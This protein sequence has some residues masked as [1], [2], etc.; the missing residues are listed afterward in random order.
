MVRGISP[1]YHYLNWNPITDLSSG[2]ILPRDALHI[3]YVQPTRSTA[4]QIANIKTRLMVPKPRNRP[5]RRLL[6]PRPDAGHPNSKLHPS[7]RIRATRR[8]K[9]PS[10]MAV[11]VH[12]LRGDHHPRR[13]PG[14]H[15]PPRNARQTEPNCAKQIRHPTRKDSTPKSRTRGPRIQR[16][17]ENLC[18]G[19]TELEVLG[20]VVGG[21]FLL[22]RVRANQHG[23]VPSLVEES[24]SVLD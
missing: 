4:Q 15:S 17:M 18:T 23:W 16:L 24:E 13:H 5:T 1:I 10:R 6:L 12:H 22:E 11:D 14:I 8:S 21:H 19:A 7:W 2:C 3:R 9:R 20:V